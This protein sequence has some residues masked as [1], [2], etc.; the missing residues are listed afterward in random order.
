MFN[1]IH[2][3]FNSIW[4]IKAKPKNSIIRYL[5]KHITSFSILILLFFIILVST[6]VNSLL[7]KHSGTIHS[8]YK[9]SYIY[10]HLTS[11]VVIALV[12][13][14]MFK[15]LG[16]AKVYWKPALLGGFIYFFFI[17]NRKNSHWDVHRT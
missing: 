7:M 14:L 5:T 12:F 3:S 15:F 2:N 10:E 8:N 1:Q 17:C 11:F 13:A 9:L 4:N 6:T 16:D